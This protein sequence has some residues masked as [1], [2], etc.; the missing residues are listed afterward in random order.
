MFGLRQVARRREPDP[1]G[2]SR[3]RYCSR[4]RFDHDMHVLR[5]HHGVRRRHD[6]SRTQRG[7]G[8]RHRWRRAHSDDP[9]SAR[10]SEVLM[11]WL[12]WLI[13]ATTAIT[14]VMLLPVIFIA[15]IERDLE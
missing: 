1:R 10:Q 12:I 4:S 2:R 7:R 8:A 5:A 15:A 6:V 13:M 9:A 14:I 11:D 3:A